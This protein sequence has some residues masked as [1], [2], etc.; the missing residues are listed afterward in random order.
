METPN[1]FK[2][3]ESDAVCPPHLKNEIV[4]EIDL[5]RNAIT[6]V[7]VYIG[8]LFDLAAVLADPLLIMPTEKKPSL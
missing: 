8:D 6:L 3:F 4:S 2:E 7:D 1:P 5:I